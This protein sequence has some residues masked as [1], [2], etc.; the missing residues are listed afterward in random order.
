MKALKIG[1]AKWRCGANEKGKLPVLDDV[2]HTYNGRAAIVN[3]LLS[4]FC[5]IRLSLTSHTDYLFF[6]VLFP[7]P[8]KKSYVS[9]W[10]YTFVHALRDIGGRS[11]I[12]AVVT[13]CP[14][15][16]RCTL[17]SYD[18]GGKQLGMYPGD[19]GVD[20]TSFMTM[21]K[22]WVGPLGLLTQMNKGAH[23]QF[24]VCGLTQADQN[25]HFWCPI[26]VRLM[27]MHL[28][29]CNILKCQYVY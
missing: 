21:G 25:R 17:Y 6:L 2:H 28:N 26:C 1:A 18:Q 14:S 27:Q 10:L 7:S 9:S 22:K 19:D 12:L 24:C 8:R 29:S 15:Q 5:R 16:R 20:A 4:D 11:W 13:V 3:S 23:N